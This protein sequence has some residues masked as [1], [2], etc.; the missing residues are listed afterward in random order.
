MAVNNAMITGT[1]GIMDWFDDNATSPYFSVWSGPKEMNFSY[2]EDDVDN[3]RALLE[4]NIAAFE[5]NGLGSILTLKLH[6]K[7]DKAGYITNATPHYASIK[8]RPAPLETA[9]YNP[10]MIGAMPNQNSHLSNQI[11]DLN[12]KFNMLM[13]KISADEFEEEEE[14]KSTFQNWLESPHVQGL[15]MAGISKFLG[16]DATGAA[17]QG[18]AGINENSENEAIDI[19]DSLMAKGVTI[20]HLRKLNEMNAAKLN[21]LLLM[22]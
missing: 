19:L 6:P 1:R 15:M 8:F 5:Q 18:I 12:E 4:K 20:E 14:P 7:K 2:N 13:S 22:L 17:V 9:Y 11:A 3:A 10:S 16:L 21:S